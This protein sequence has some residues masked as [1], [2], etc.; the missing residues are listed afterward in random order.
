MKFVSWNVYKELNEWA[1]KDNLGERLEV[2]G[3][4]KNTAVKSFQP[5]YKNEAQFNIHTHP[6]T[7]EG[8][9][10]YADPSPSDWNNVTKYPDLFV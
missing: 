6:G 9:G 4:D 5:S 10:G 2:R 3:W 8:V 7:K 1:Y